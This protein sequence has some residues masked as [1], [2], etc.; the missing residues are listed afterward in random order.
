M[1][2]YIYI[3]N[4]LILL[5]WI[6]LIW[7]HILHIN[8]LPKYSLHKLMKSVSSV[9]IALWGIPDFL[10][11]DAKMKQDCNWIYRTKVLLTPQSILSSLY[12]SVYTMQSILLNLYSS[13]Y[14][15]ESILFS[16]YSW[17]YTLQSILF[18]VSLNCIL[19]ILSNPSPDVTIFIPA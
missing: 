14:T 9:Y 10:A 12:S 7:R 5:G 8:I 2:I 15:L 18:S 6:D 11:M 13:I 3:I 17:V 4:I 1:Y 19:S 16:L